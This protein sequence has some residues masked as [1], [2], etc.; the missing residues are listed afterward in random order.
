M[1]YNKYKKGVRTMWRIT[2][3]WLEKKERDIKSANWD[4][5][6]WEETKADRVQIKLYDDDNELYFDGESNAIHKSSG[7]A[8]EPLDWARYDSGC[9]YMKYKDPETGE[10]K[11][12]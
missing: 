3:D 12:L 2:Y 10:W 5:A 11:V 7:P 9:A 1:F 8:F 4:D 6:K